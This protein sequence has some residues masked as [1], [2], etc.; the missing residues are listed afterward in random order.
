MRSFIS[1]F[2]L[3]TLLFFGCVLQAHAE[4]SLPSEWKTSTHGNL[5]LDSTE[6]FESIPPTN[7][8]L[9]TARASVELNAR[10]NDW[11][12]KLVPLAQVDPINNSNSERAWIDAQAAYTQYQSNGWTLQLGMNTFTW[13]VTDGYNP[14]DVV[15]ARR[16]QE[17]LNPDKL[18]A[19]SVYFTKKK[20]TSRQ[21]QSLATETS[22]FNDF[23][24][25]WNT[26]RDFKSSSRSSV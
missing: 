12:F 2:G 3:V 17:P 8:I 11:R 21:Q 10:H 15:S 13:G 25:R 24:R 4:D 9:E 6:Y 23:G 22:F 14:L 7:S 26:I 16:Y 18:G 20:R 5:E 19:P 1:R